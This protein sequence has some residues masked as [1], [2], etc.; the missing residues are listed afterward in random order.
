M[1]EPDDDQGQPSVEA[2]EDWVID[3]CGVDAGDITAWREL[4]LP[5][6]TTTFPKLHSL[7]TSLISFAGLTSLDVSRN[8]LASF[9]GLS[10]LSQL[11]RLN[12]YFNQVVSLQDLSRLK[13]NR[14]LSH[15]DCRLNPVARNHPDFRLHAL[16]TLPQLQRLDERDVRPAER[17]QALAY[18][19]SDGGGR[20]AG[21]AAGSERGSWSSVDGGGGREPRRGEHDS[22][23][24]QRAARALLQQDDDD[25]DDDSDSDSDRGGR[26]RAAEPAR[27]KGRG[28]GYE[29]PPTRSTNE[30]VS[31]FHGL[32]P[33]VAQPQTR[34]PARGDGSSVAGYSEQDFDQVPQAVAAALAKCESEQRRRQAAEAELDEMRSQMRSHMADTA[35][36]RRELADTTATAASRDA[37][38]ADE[39]AEAKRWRQ[40]AEAAESRLGKL[41]EDAAGRSVKH[42]AVSMEVGRLEQQLATSQQLHNTMVEERSEMMSQVESAKTLAQSAATAAAEREKKSVSESRSL[43]NEITVAERYL[44]EARHRIELLSSELTNARELATREA[45]RYE[46]TTELTQMLREAHGSLAA[47]NDSLRKECDGLHNRYNMDAD[48]WKRNFAEL[49]KQYESYGDL[50]KLTASLLKPSYADLAGAE[51]PSPARGYFSDGDVALARGFPA[52]ASPSRFQAPKGSV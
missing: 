19:P 7:G 10:S 39:S 34:S 52:S 8:A 16:H 46:Q 3:R 45:D 21:S 37:E 43:R 17:R 5:G 40:R 12:F 29:V 24:L 6:Y 15:L 14:Q 33:P 22:A 38:H 50:G 31:S 9:E 1:N 41:E 30:D 48:Q 2:T 27:G 35:R 51:P 11:Q 4:A 47:S 13:A 25:E 26:R 36:L 44:E 42:E 18:A 32:Q 20:Q 23:S 28:K 49:K